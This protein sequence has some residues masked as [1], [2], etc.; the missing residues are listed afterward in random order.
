MNQFANTRRYLQLKIKLSKK[1][2]II[3]DVVDWRISSQCN[4]VFVAIPVEY[5]SLM[6]R[7]EKGNVL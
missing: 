4:V 5:F 1:F 3:K 6:K 2:I 7:L